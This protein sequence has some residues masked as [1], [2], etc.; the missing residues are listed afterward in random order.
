MKQKLEAN[1]N[2]AASPDLSSRRKQNRIW[3]PVL[4]EEG[5]AEDDYRQA[6]AQRSVKDKTVNGPQIQKRN[7]S[8]AGSPDSFEEIDVLDKAKPTLKGLLQKAAAEVIEREGDD[9][10][11]SSTVSRTRTSK[12]PYAVPGTE[13]DEDTKKKLSKAS[14]VAQEILST[15][16][17]FL[18][19]IKLLNEDF[20]DF[21]KQGN[22][23]RLR[24][25]SILLEKRENRDHI[26]DK[27]LDD[28]FM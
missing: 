27:E 8:A 28:I 7:Q 11:Y 10:L 13:G 26:T 14:K 18:A 16:K 5:G 3:A 12:S 1:E 4:R 23:S 6:A 15:E 19:I 2:Q 17:N 9:R 20:K 21:V 22:Q 24:R 25:K